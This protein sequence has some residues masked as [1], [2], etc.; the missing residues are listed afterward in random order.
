MIDFN[1]DG[2]AL[3]FSGG[4]S[5]QFEITLAGLTA[6]SFDFLSA[7]GGGSTG[8][9]NAVAHLLGLGAEEDSAWVATPEPATMLL[10]G[11]GGLALRRRKA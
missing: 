8:P 3:A 1:S 11:L 4:E 9:F 7:P 2:P 6:N 10:L 5:V